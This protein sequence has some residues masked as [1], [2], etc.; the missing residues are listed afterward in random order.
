MLSLTLLTLLPLASAVPRLTA[1]QG[2]LTVAKSSAQHTSLKSAVAALS[3]TTTSAQCIFIGPGTYN[4]Q[5]L[6]PSTLKSPLIIYGSTS[7]DATYKSNT[8]TL[9]SSLS[10]ANGLSNDE[11]GTLRVH[12]KAG[13]K[14][15]NIDMVNGYGKG[16]QAVALSVQGGGG[17][18]VYGGRMVGFQ[19]TLLANE[20]KTFVAKSLVQGATD[21]VFGRRGI[22]WFQGVDVMV[23]EASVGY[24]TASGRQLASD[25]GYYVFDNCV[26]A[27]AD[28]HSVAN[29]AYY[30][31]RPWAAFAR[32]VFQ[33]SNLEAVIN[34]AGWRIWNTGDERTSNVLF[35]EY[36]NTGTGS[37][38]TRASFSKKLGALV[39]MAE[40]LGS[41]YST[42]WWFDRNYL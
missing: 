5:V 2:C 33:R 22:A 39:T 19:D 15:Y 24:I 38:G 23:V 1:P 32:V 14:I 41:D 30:L 8:V 6:V 21:F 13:V 29:G 27:A 40:V 36:G 17:V 20:G 31:G 12:S 11:T 35:G 10:Q 26:V 7:D 37:Q 3:L 16:S 25:P 4:E 34:S 42:A 28:A 9:L 18:G